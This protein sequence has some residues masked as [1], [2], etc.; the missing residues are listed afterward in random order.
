METIEGYGLNEGLKADFFY[1][2]I[3]KSLE[4]LYENDKALSMIP[5]FHGENY[6]LLGPAEI[7]PPDRSPE[8]RFIHRGHRENRKRGR[9]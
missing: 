3:H 7:S 6:I 5:W 2:T 1:M 9:V 4:V 8:F